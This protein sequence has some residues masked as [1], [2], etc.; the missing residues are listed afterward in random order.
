MNGLFNI[1]VYLRHAIVALELKDFQIFNIGCLK[2]I[3]N[4]LSP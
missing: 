1:Y 4:L 3:S 2:M